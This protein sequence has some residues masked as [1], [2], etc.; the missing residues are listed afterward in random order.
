M[1]F[2]EKVTRLIEH[3]KAVESRKMTLPKRI[4]GVALAVA[5]VCLI[6]WALAP[7]GSFF[8]HDAPSEWE[9]QPSQKQLAARGVIPAASPTPSVTLPRPGDS[10]S[11]PDA[12]A[13]EVPGIRAAP[14]SRRRAA[15]RMPLLRPSPSGATAGVPH[16]AK[17]HHRHLLGLGKLWHWVRH[18][19]GKHPSSN[20]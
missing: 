17:R 14:L 15:V 7:R 12:T 11:L 16:P 4:A 5:F 8:G 20:Q 9:Y 2:S 18:G 1:N 10:R 3:T 19:H 13:A 6:L